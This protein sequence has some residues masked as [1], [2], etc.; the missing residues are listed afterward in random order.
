MIFFS[1]CPLCYAT[2]LE[3]QTFE[4]ESQFKL[5]NPEEYARDIERLADSSTHVRGVKKYC[6]LNDLKYFHSKNN[7]INDVMHTLFQG[8]FIPKYVFFKSSNSSISFF[9]RL[10]SECYERCCLFSLE[11][12]LHN[13]GVFQQ[14]HARRFQSPSRR[15]E[16]QTV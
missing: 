5:R 16:K 2:R 14:S 1:S 10:D 8:C 7:W 15:K 3:M 4:K 6:K 13:T 11:G 9:I 12:R